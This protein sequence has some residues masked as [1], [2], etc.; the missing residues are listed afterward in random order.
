MAYLEVLIAAIAAFALGAV[1]YTALFGKT[2]QAETG[3]SEEAAKSRVAVTHGLAF[4]MMFV[5]A[6]STNFVIGFHDVAEQTFVH[7]AFHGMLSAL[8]VA[9]PAVAI[10]YLYQL[11]SMR[12]FLID[13]AYLV[14]FMALQGGVLAALKL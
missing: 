9:L 14:A 4:V 7:G 5:L 3:I 12:L 8:T 2:W 1:W 6:Y 13:G 11:K 10:N